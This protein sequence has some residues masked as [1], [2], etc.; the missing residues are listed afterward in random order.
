MQGVDTSFG[1]CVQMLGNIAPADASPSGARKLGAKARR[2]GQLIALGLPVP[3]SICVATNAFER[4]L[5]ENDATAEVYRLATRLPDERARR[6]LIDLAYAYEI[7]VDL[8]AALE[9]AMREIAP[10]CASH[11]LLAVRSSAL[12][13]DGEK[14]SFAGQYVSR[15]GVSPRAVWPAIRACWASA[16]SAEAVGYRARTEH[17]HHATQ[18]AVVVQ[19]MV[20]AQVSAVA[21]TRDPTVEREDMMVN[22]ARGL[23]EGI[24]STGV[25]ADTYRIA[26]D[27]M[28]VRASN[29]GEQATKVVLC[30]AGGTESVAAVSGRLCLTHA[31]VT[32]LARIALEIE[33]L[34]G[35]PAD[36][37]AA[38]ADDTWHILQARPI[39]TLPTDAHTLRSSAGALS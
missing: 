22:A 4:Y 21:F 12:D 20:N 39:T 9:Q 29:V 38:F 34:L 7:P 19:P 1:D 35:A 27:T 6:E 24:V 33:R 3:P 15:L 28:L 18:V 11:P 13:E 8:T 37:E 14:S 23:G 36:I 17:P 10:P 31:V 5:A 25:S 2:L 26:R 16:W 32:S 30:P